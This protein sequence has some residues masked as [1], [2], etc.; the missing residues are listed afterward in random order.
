MRITRGFETGSWRLVIVLSAALAAWGCSNRAGGEDPVSRPERSSAQT[1]G[2][3]KQLKAERTK[4]GAE[5]PDKIVKTDEEWR[6]ILTE[7]QYRVTRECGTE[8][9][10]TGKYYRFKGE[11]TYLC[12]ACGGELFSSD[13]KYDSGSGWP[14]FWAPAADSSI[15]EHADKSLGM[16][17]VEVRCSRCGAHLGHVF[18][19]GPRPTGLRYCINS[20][21][22]DFA[23]ADK[24]TAAG[25]EPKDKGSE[26]K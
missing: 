6:K 11:G 9:P 25:E 8:P 2:E 7:E 21:A 24:D 5:V 13:T 12:V 19:D 15:S 3:T 26:K 17:R 4:E 20:A 14:S 22:L 16:V 1:E 10:F 18:E 23:P